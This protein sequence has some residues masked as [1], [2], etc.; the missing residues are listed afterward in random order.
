MGPLFPN[1]YMMAM[2]TVPHF[3]R[4][5]FS[6]SLTSPS[7]V[8][9]PLP[10]SFLGPLSRNPKSPALVCHAQLLTVC[11]FI[12]QSEPTGD[13]VPQSDTADRCLGENIISMRI[14]T[15]THCDL[16]FLSGLSYP[17]HPDPRLRVVRAR[18]H[19]LAP[20]RFIWEKNL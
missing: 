2:L 20:G 14:Q 17:L 4:G 7:M 6:S 19:C 10:P 12:Y 3:L 9:L 8:D 16:P 11:I 15:A 1:S 18:K 13:R 5:S